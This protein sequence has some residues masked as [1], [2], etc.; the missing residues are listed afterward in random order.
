MFFSESISIGDIIVNT[1][2]GN[3][4]ILKAKHQIIIVDFKYIC[5]TNSAYKNI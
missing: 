4:D 3:V 2:G 5:K 1:L